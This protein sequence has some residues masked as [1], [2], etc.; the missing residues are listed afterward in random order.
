MI[1]DKEIPFDKFE[2][3]DDEVRAS[4]KLIHSGLAELQN[5]NGGNDF[6][7][8]PFLLLSNGFEKLLKLFICFYHWEQYGQFPT[9]EDFKKKKNDNGHNLLF[10]KEKITT[11]Y[12]VA[13]TPALKK[14]LNILINDKTLN[15]LIDFLGEFGQSSRYYNLDVIISKPKRNS[16]DIK[17]LW[18][19]METYLLLA[20]MELSNKFKLEEIKKKNEQVKVKIIVL[21]EILARALTRQ[22]IFGKLGQA[23]RFKGTI[24]TFLSLND[25]ELGQ[26]DYRELI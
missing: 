24:G 14:D 9:M 21:L 3:L 18:E 26:R 10:L 8:L 6:Y 16:K 23:Q 7:Y 20:D 15:Q 12:F 19:R 4:I 22:F 13:S 2:A 5:V 1:K 25:D 17:Q 11:D